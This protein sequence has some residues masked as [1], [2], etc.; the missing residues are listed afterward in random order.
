MKQLF[1]KAAVWGDLHLGEKSNSQLHNTDCIEYIKWFVETAQNNNCDCC[2]FLGD[3]FHNRNNTNLM[4][5][6]YGLQGL[7]LLSEAFPRTI[8]IPGNHDLFFKDQRTVSSIAWAEHIPNIEIFNDITYID[9]TV[10]VPWLVGEEHKQLFKQKAQYMF[11]HFEL[12]SFM[13]NAHV[14]MPDVGELKAHHFS[15]FGHVFSGHFH[16][17]QSKLNIT[18]IGNTFP[19]NFSDVDDDDR[20]MMILPWGEDPTFIPWPDAPKYR[21]VKIS[22]LVVNPAKYLSKKG[23]VKIIMD[24]NISY[25]EASYIKESL[26][27]EFELREL[28][29]IS[30]NKDM[31][32]TDPSPNGNIKF[33]S[34][35]T[36]VQGQITAIDSEFYDAN[37]LLDIYR[38]L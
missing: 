22:E 29:L 3:Y 7:R 19:H 26:I 12:P 11:G 8:M 23:Y 4:T 32:S 6:N 31:H 21:S 27:N 10:F 20:G 30:L 14:V 25:E 1:K 28:S 2:I 17:R 13:M 15:D 9:D 35:D 34:V 38:G 37:V 18:Y 33:Q 16:K 36:I 5:M 24:T